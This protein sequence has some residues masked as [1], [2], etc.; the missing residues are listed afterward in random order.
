MYRCIM[1]ALWFLDPRQGD[2]NVTWS[3]KSYKHV[4]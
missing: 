2:Q 4:W 1:N 3:W